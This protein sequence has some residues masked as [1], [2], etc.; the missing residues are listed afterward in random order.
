MCYLHLFSVN[1]KALAVD[2]LDTQLEQIAVEGNRIVTT[3]RR[4]NIEIRNLFRLDFRSY[5]YLIT[6]VIIHI[7]SLEV[8][9]SLPLGESVSSLHLTNHGSHIL[10]GLSNGHLYVLAAV[11]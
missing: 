11:S 9:A 3:D 8:L 1:G 4:G 2:C 10:V 5:T 6:T 7:I